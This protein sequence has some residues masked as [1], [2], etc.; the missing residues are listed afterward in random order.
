MTRL[1]DAPVRARRPHRA[2]SVAAVAFVALVG[3]AG[4]RAA[5]SVLITPL[6]DEFG[7]S[8]GTISAAVSIN[9][10]LYGVISPFAAALMEKLGMRRVV[11]GALLLV[12]AGSGLTVFMTASW[13]LLLL[14]GVCVGVGTG[15][16]AL[17]FVATVT[18]RWFIRHQGLVS[19][20][21]TAAGAAG[22]L[23]FLPVVALLA[24]D[25]GWRPASLAV[26]FAALAVVPL[27]LLALRDH[28]RD[29]GTTAYGADPAAPPTTQAPNPGHAA[30]RALRVL[31]V[32]VRNRTFWLLAGG[33]AICG[34]STN[35]LIGTHFV[36]AAHDHGMPAT[37]AASLLA[38]VG[39]FDV[40]GTIAS[41][42]LTDKVDPRLL[43]GAYY[44]LR[45][46]SLLVLPHLFAATT[47]PPMWGFVVFYG[48]DWVATVPPTV[49]LCRRVFGAD[50][51][52]VFGW[53]F[54]SHQVGAAL[55]ATGAGLIRDHHGGYDPAWYL[56]GGLCALAAVMSLRITSQRQ[57]AGAPGAA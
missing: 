18:S 39:L 6:H 31:R 10:V 21:L 8:T 17:T 41:G 25:H 26:S 30:A 49:A 33:F 5:P 27:V 57:P 16:M 2:W 34:A 7:W 23:V 4:F 24:R 40:A 1:D 13:Q 52:I 22:Q 32:A 28:P 29:V 44:S 42:W 37:T 54:A 9:L 51:P 53:V 14:W 35:G 55:A 47:E 12:A 45:G 3:A 43:L 19:G 46:A 11:T 38:L 50:G 15:S 20:V 56:A 48:L 36:P